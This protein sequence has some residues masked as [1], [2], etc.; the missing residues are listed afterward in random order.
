MPWSSE[1][2]DFGGALLANT[3]LTASTAR[4]LH[5]ARPPMSSK[6]A[7]VGDFEAQTYRRDSDLIL[8]AQS[9]KRGE[10]ALRRK[11]RTVLSA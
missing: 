7:G 11:R 3:A 8:T 4:P 9:Q 6:S 5:A 1:A 2:Y 10:D